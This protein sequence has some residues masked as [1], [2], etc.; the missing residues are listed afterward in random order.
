MRASKSIAAAVLAAG[1]VLFLALP[2]IGAAARADEP[3]VIR[4]GW[5]SM[6]NSL[7]PM[8]FENKAIMRHLG[9][10]YIVEPIHFTGTSPEIQAIAA[11]QIDIITLGFSTLAAGV[12]NAGLDLRVVADSFQDGVPGYLSSPFMV[13]NDSGIRRIEDLKGKVLVTNAIGGSLDVA[14][15]ALLRKHAMEDKRDVTIIEAAFPNMNA[16]LLGRKVDMVSLT[17]PFTYDPALEQNAHVLARM[18][19]GVGQS[20]MI[21]LAARKDYLEQNRQALY[22]FFEDMLVGV[23]WFLDPANRS[24]ALAIVARLSQQPPERLQYLY[25]KDDFYRSPDARPNLD[26]MQHDMETQVQLGFLKQAIDVRQY[27]DLSFIDEAA[28]RLKP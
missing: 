20:Q 18:K 21:V 17:P 10:T 19:D 7:S 24:E 12:L 22:D 26:A 14:L 9:K 27:T 13:R 11:K 25:T 5:V 1:A 23:R 8:I 16:M 3:L 2:F 4:H 28:R 15:R 6:T